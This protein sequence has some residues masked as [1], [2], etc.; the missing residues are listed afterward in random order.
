PGPH[1][2]LGYAGPHVALG[3]AGPHAVLRYGS[4]GELKLAVS[5]V[6]MSRPSMAR[7]RTSQLTWT[8]NRVSGSKPWLVWTT[9]TGPEQTSSRS[10]SAA[11]RASAIAVAWSFW[12]DPARAASRAAPSNAPRPSTSCPKATRTRMNRI[13]TGARITT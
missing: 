1:A 9:V 11:A 8:L 6:G 4:S 3:Y 5:V 2:V 7:P 10:A 13:M 12:I